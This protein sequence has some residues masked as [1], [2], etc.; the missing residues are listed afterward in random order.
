MIPKAEAIG[1]LS[2]EDVFKIL[3]AKAWSI[4]IGFGASAARYSLSSIT[5]AIYLLK[6][7]VGES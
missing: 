5:K 6:E 1:I 7:M 3:P 4:K 2:D